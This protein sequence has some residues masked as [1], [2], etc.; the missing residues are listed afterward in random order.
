MLDM[1]DPSETPQRPR[2]SVS[3][4][5]PTRG[6]A[7]ERTAMASSP[8]GVSRRHVQVSTGAS[9][10]TP[11][12]PNSRGCKNVRHWNGEALVHLPSGATGKPRIILPSARVLSQEHFQK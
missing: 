4:H 6:P 7:R 2:P 1:A 11:T 5:G 9:M 3:G 12:L 8:P 10:E